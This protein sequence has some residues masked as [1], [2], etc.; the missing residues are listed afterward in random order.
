MKYNNIV[1]P[2]ATFV[3][4][5]SLG[6]MP[7][8]GAAEAKYYACVVK[9]TGAMRQVAASTKCKATEKKI[10]WSAGS[11]VGPAGPQGPTGPTGPAGAVGPAGPAGPQGAPG[12]DGVDGADGINGRDGIDGVDGVEGAAGPIGPQGLQGIQ[13]P[14]G[15]AGAAGAAG[16]GYVGVTSTTSNT[17]GSGTK[18]F[19][20]TSGTAF[21]TGARVRIASTTS[22][23]NFVEGIASVTGTSMSVAVDLFKGAGTFTA[24]TVNLAGQ[25]GDIGLTGLDGLPGASAA[26]LVGLDCEVNGD[27][28]TELGIYDWVELTP[29]SNIWIVACDGTLR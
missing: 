4:G 9:K 1:F 20:I 14:T 24:W 10:A 6:S 25:K 11:L 29:G 5:L 3:V 7:S 22:P 19:T 15:P 17:I 18:V 21:S 26:E 27:D 13:G 2:L 28:S 16:P 8:V 23:T 12:R